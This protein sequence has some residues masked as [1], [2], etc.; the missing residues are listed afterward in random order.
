MP[1]NLEIK[2]KLASHKEVKGI[3]KKNKITFEGLLLQKDIYYKVNKG[4]LKLRIENDIQTLIFYDR[5][6]KSKK[7]WSDYH[8]LEIDNSDANKYLKRFLEVLTIVNKKRELY[9][10]KNTRIHLDY[11]KGL[12][13][14]LEL[15]TRVVNGLKDA[16]KRFAFMMDLLKLWDKKEIRASYKDL[17]L[18]KDKK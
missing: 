15:E 18:L 2:V 3:L 17:L 7:R 4:L 1:K 16:E 13:C 6:E 14:F 12:G 10:Y 9:H 8:L 11:V 5:N